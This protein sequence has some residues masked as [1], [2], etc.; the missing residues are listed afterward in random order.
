M[1]VTIDIRIVSYHVES[2][3]SSKVQNRNSCKPDMINLL[4]SITILLRLRN[5]W[6]NN[7]KLARNNR[8]PS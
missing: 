7:K 6:T 1:L 3:L 8:L 4:F 2:L 5:T